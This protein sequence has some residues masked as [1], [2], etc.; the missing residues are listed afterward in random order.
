MTATTLPSST[1]TRSSRFFPRGIEETRQV[2]RSI[3]A[4]G[5]VPRR[6]KVTVRKRRLWILFAGSAA[7]M[8]EERLP[9]FFI[10]GVGRGQGLQR[11]TGEEGAGGVRKERSR[12]GEGVRDQVRLVTGSSTDGAVDGA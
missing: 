3:K 9:K 7:R 6:V 5:Q 8:G 4:P 12:R 1:P 11:R 10:L 2:D